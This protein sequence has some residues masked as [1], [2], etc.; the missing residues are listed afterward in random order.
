M[1]PSVY[2]VDGQLTSPKFADAFARGCGG[3][4]VRD[5][6]PGAWAGF[7][8]PYNWDLLMQAIKNGDDFYYGDHAYFG[9]GKYYKVTKNR[10][11]HDG[12]GDYDFKRLRRFHEKAKEWKKGGTNIIVCP[13]SDDHHKRFGETFWTDRVIKTLNKNTDRRIIIRTKKT[14]RPLMQDLQ[15]AHCVITHTSNAAVEAIMNGIPAIVTG[16]SAASRMAL[17]DPANVERPYYPDGRM[18]WAAAL[19]H[20]QWT[21]DEIAQ[22][23]CWEAIK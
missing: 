14:R 2:V 23:K 18:E 6:V 15:D 7:G 10:F 21:L 22:G 4:I 20:N 17:S 16:D 19:A 1:I 5:Y 13:Q 12:T 11:Q 3:T 9:R 8:S